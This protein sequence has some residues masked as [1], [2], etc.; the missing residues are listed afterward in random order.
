MLEMLDETNSLGRF[1]RTVA[2]KM[3]AFLVDET[4]V[5]LLCSVLGNIFFL[6][7]SERLFGG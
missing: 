7:I 1:M 4:T 6:E 3:T 5:M 2:S